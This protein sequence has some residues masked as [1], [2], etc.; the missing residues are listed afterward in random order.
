MG[1]GSTAADDSGVVATGT[2][3]AGR[4]R[5]G[6][7]L[8]SGGMG[9][10]YRGEHTA[11]GKPVAVKVLHE[12]L[13][14]NREAAMRFQ[15]EAIASGRLD[16]PNIVSVMDFGVLDDGCLY[17]VMEALDGEHLGQRIAR[18]KRIP[19]TDALVIAR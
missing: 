2:V 19:W 9:R 6:G 4:Y 16:H 13:G 5:I 10:V 3:L 7:V 14:G 1:M 17:L 11:I 8:G 18:E 15:R 12:A